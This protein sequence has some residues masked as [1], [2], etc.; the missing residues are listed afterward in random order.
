MIFI[1]K[2]ICELVIIDWILQI[3]TLRPIL[4]SMVN[5]IMI[6]MAYIMMN[7]VPIN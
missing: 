2:I 6:V 1:G 5:N 3:S 4:K 7:C